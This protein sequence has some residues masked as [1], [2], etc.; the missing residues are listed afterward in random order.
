MTEHPPGAICI[1][2]GELSRYPHFTHSMLNLLCPP[3]TKVE[4][5][6]GLN[7]AANFNAGVRRAMANPEL[8]W[9][10]I[11][12]DDH[13]FDPTV[14]LRLL[15]RE[16]DIVVPL[17]VRR[18]PP[19][20]P[21]LFKEPTD[22]TPEGQFPPFHWDELPSRGLLEVYT[23][24]SAGMLIRRRVLERIGD[25]WFE[26]GKMGVELTNEDT[27][28]CLKA[29]RAGFQ[30]H[31]DMEVSLD[32]WTPVSFR[33]TYKD[34]EWTV[35]INLGKD[36]QVALPPRMLSSLVSIVKEESK[37]M[38]EKSRSTPGIILA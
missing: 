38:Y 24:G 21:V 6:M 33:P 13:E 2:S 1:A 27:H 18:Q 25:P 4:M 16:L 35:A 5:H 19:F 26:M 12:G 22:D 14:L 31:A 3:G 20:I 11:M 23:A 36:I 7:V 34:G 30:I 29:Q 37:D 8:Q 10:W 17:V 9:V 32:H 28:F 15:D